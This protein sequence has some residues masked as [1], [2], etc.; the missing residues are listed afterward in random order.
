MWPGISI[1]MVAAPE[2]GK[3]M[4]YESIRQ[5]DNRLN[6]T[7][8]DTKCSMMLFIPLLT[9]GV[10]VHDGL[11]VVAGEDEL[12]AEEEG[13]DEGELLELLQRD[14]VLQQLPLRLQREE[15]VDELL[16]VRQEVVVVVLVPSS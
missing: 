16:R 9:G 8:T 13:A 3:P 12:V 11:H 1:R 15:L 6:D 14:G 7:T 4:N 5:S 10:G 2:I